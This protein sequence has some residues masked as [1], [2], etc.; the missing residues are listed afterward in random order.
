MV[1]TTKCSVIGLSTGRNPWCD[2]RTFDNRRPRYP[3]PTSWHELGRAGLPFGLEEAALDR[4][5]WIWLRFS[6]G[7]LREQSADRGG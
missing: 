1:T 7:Q 3:L 5:S 4:V 6:D 2:E